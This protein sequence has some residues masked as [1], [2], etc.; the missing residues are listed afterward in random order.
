[1]EN[2]VTV[3]IS[4]IS[5]LV[6]VKG[7]EYQGFEIELWEDIAR[8]ANLHFEYQVCDFKDIIPLLVSKKVDVGIA[9]ITINE[10]REKLVDFSFLTLDSGL[11]IAVSKNSNKTDLKETLKTVFTEGGKIIWPAMA[12]VLTFIFIFGNLMWLV[13]RNA[14]TF[15]KNYF[16][17]IFEAFWLVICSMSTDSFGDYVPHTWIGRVITVGIIVGGVATFGLLIAQVTSFI[18][19]KKIRGQINTEADLPGKRIVTKQGTTSEVYLRK[20]GARVMLAESIEAAYKIL[21]HSDCDG[22]VYD[23]PV[24]IYHDKNDAAKTNEMIGEIFEKQ[25]YGIALQAGSKLREPIN[26]A[27]LKLRESGHYDAIYRKW[28]GDDLEME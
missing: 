1:M 13:E 25:K 20:I 18:A 6:M 2:K 27:I 11:A 28:F 3:A 5:P 9:G 7:H 26:Q 15:S 24:V 23:A 21:A 22:L 4:K 12:A 16:P 19:L 17:G 8:E 14:N 10:E